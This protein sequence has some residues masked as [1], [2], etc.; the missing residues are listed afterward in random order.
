MKIDSTSNNVFQELGLQEEDFLQRGLVLYEEASGLIIAQEDENGRIHEL[1]P[2]ACQAWRL[3]KNAAKKQG[4][5]LFIVSAFRSVS[6]QAEIIRDKHL[7]GIG[8]D[9]IFAVS[10]PPGFSEHHT[11]RA[12]DISTPGYPVLE[13]EFE[14]SEAFHWLLKN[15]QDFGF[16][17]SYPRG[18]KL[19]Y[20][21]EPWHWCYDSE[22]DTPH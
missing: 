4:H 21:Y 12:I 3:L 22:N 13:E 10:A 2:E 8:N 20:L 9:E 5:N 1:V 18:N 16:F 19:G 17:M 7:A 15:A 14:Q 11:G 6:R